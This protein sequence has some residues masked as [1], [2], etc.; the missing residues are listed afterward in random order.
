MKAVSEEGLAGIRVLD[1][2]RA[3]YIDAIVNRVYS[4]SYPYAFDNHQPVK[5][6]RAQVAG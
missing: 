2:T 1:G 6:A 3:G 4:E 5:D